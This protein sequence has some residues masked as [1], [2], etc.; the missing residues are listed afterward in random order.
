MRNR[1]VLVTK[2]N[3]ALLAK[4]NPVTSLAVGQLGIFSKLTNLSLDA[5]SDAELAR[6]F[7]LAVGIDTTGGATLND[8]RQSAGQLIR[9]S[10]ITDLNL[11][12][13]SPTQPKIV[14]IKSFKADCETEYGIRI[15]FKSKAMEQI[16]G[17][18]YLSKYFAVK[19]DCCEGGCSDTC[20]SG[21][22]NELA[23]AFVNTINADSD[24]IVIA[25]LLDYTTDGD[26]PVV[27][28]VE[29]Y[30]AWIADEDNEGDCL[31][32]RL[33][34]VP[35]NIVNWC[36]VN[37][38]YV[39]F[40]EMDIFVS[41]VEGFDCNGSVTVVQEFIAERG[42][43]YDIAQLEQEFSGEADYGNGVYRSSA[44]TG[45]P[46][47]NYNAIAVRTA[48]YLTV[49]IGY[50][51]TASNGG[52]RTDTLTNLE[53]LVAIPCADENTR[54]SI[55]AILDV[56]LNG[57]FDGLTNDEAACPACNIPNT[58]ETAELTGATDGIA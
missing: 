41:L 10:E 14:D 45:I 29:D 5:T 3:V 16:S 48:Q 31:G 21:N 17:Y 15:Q 55:V 22:C 56:L 23:L 26:N 1:T 42:S 27:V 32:I 46:F 13:Y 36:N 49:S 51:N 39:S 18:N 20:P 47:D 4:N 11:A 28:A 52:V 8:V 7:Y 43:G 53:T 37:Q 35:D 9:R 19:T 50:K 40:R 6:E 34:T 33:T 24:A 2:G 57:M 38:K 30:A 58:V 54:N 44:I 12:C 25:E